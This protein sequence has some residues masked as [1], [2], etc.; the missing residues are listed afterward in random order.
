MDL[1][2]TRQIRAAG[3]D[4]SR[5]KFHS[6]RRGAIQ[7]AIRLEPRLQLIRL[8]SDHSSSA[9]DCYTA[10]PASKRF[11]LTSSMVASM[12]ALGATPSL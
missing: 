11:D 12:N 1:V 10:L 9:F 5:Y 3:L 6:F 8:Q 4:I 7:M 2:L